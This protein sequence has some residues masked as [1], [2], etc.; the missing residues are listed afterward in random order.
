MHSFFSVACSQY[1]ILIL[2]FCVGH[3]IFASGGPPPRP[4]PEFL[5]TKMSCSDEFES[6]PLLRIS[7]QQKLKRHP[8]LENE[9]ETENSKKKAAQQV[10]WRLQTRYGSC[11]YL[12]RMRKPPQPAGGPLS[13]KIKRKFRFL[14]AIS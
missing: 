6:E 12:V 4:G 9:A 8:D 11:D 1:S 2:F 13:R 14:A 7:G 10:P 3:F 5:K